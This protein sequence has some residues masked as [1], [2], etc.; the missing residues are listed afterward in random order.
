MKRVKQRVTRTVANNTPG[1]AE[2]KIGAEI[3]WEGERWRVVGFV[4]RGPS[5]LHSETYIQLERL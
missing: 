5:S 1:V 2:I 4:Q 3:G